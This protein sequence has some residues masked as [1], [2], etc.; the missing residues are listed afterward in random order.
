ME[1]T[2]EYEFFFVGGSC[3]SFV[4]SIFAYYGN[5]PLGK[6]YKI[7]PITGDCHN[8]S[9]PHH[10]VIA[11]LDP[12]KKLILIDFDDDDIPIILRMSFYKAMWPQICK[13]PNLIN[14]YCGGSV[15]HIDPTDFETLKNT[16]LRDPN[17]LIFPDWREKVKKVNPVLTIKFKDIMFGNLNQMIASFFHSTTLPEVDDLINEYREINKKYIDGV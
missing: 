11:D 3:G 17:Y 2:N 10:H 6:L 7:N 9:M 1:I 15:S 8:P 13:D 5:Y 12:T 16:V 14:V 4:K